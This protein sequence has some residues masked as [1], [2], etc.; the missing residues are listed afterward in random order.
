[1]A[2]VFR[3][4]LIARLI[5]S[6][7]A[8]GLEEDD[9]VNLLALFAP[10]P[11]RPFSLTDWPNPKRAKPPQKS[12]APADRRPL[13]SP[14]PSR[15][16]AQYDWRSPVRAKRPQKSDAPTDRRVLVSPNPSRP[17]DQEDWPNPARRS[18][19]QALLQSASIPDAVVVP[20][21]SADDWTHPA[22]RKQVQESDAPAD[23]LS[24]RGQPTR[25]S[26]WPKPYRVAFRPTPFDAPNLLPLTGTP[27]ANYDWTN[28]ARRGYRVEEEIGWPSLLETT[29]QPFLQQTTEW[30]NPARAAR[31]QQPETTSNP[32][33][34][35][36]SILPFA[37]SDW[38]N[39]WPLR[40]PQT[41]TAQP[42][43][44]SS[45]ATAPGTTLVVTASIIPGQATG[46][47][48]AT[49]G[50]GVH[51]GFPP[52]FGTFAPAVVNGIARGRL[53]VVYA[54]LIPGRAEGG[55]TANG[56]TIE[57]RA[58]LI[59]GEA[60][61]AAEA[62]GA[63]IAANVTLIPGKASGVDNFALDNDFMLAA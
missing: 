5:P 36:A 27:F 21:F 20:P 49:G 51:P 2:T 50:G 59:P 24:L 55:V 52:G 19:K 7:R 42:T 22:R 60:T 63:V 10:N 58:S 12:D 44:G 46:T 23:S 29:L 62:L 15:P 43:V 45:G 1:M 3:P 18:Q 14:N 30:P 4:P 47:G 17:F 9:D 41:T 11:S 57:A 53:L 35:V 16:F 39:P 34:V 40:Q 37:L 8:K 6:K 13:A 38:P 61:G 54:S 48:Q 56:A 33:L 26:D 28:A 25:L 32:T 31:R